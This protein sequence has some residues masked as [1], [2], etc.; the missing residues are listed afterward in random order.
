MIGLIKSEIVTL[1]C[2][3]VMLFS[4]LSQFNKYDNRCVTNKVI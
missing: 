2:E 4:Y 1:F 3:I